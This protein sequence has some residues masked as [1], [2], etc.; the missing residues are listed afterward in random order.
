MSDYEELQS[1]I[2][3]IVDAAI[4]S[5]MINHTYMKSGNGEWW[6]SQD[7]GITVYSDGH[8][9]LTQSGLGP[10]RDPDPFAHGEWNP[11]A[12]W[13]KWRTEIPAAFTNW[14]SL[15]DPKVCDGA[16]KDNGKVR[17]TIGLEP[18][19]SKQSLNPQGVALAKDVHTIS[20]TMAK[21]AGKA[22]LEFT[23]TVVTPLNTAIPQQYA[24]AYLLGVLLQAEKNVW[25]KARK[26]VM[27]IAD[28]AKEAMEKAN[29]AEGGGGELP[30]WVELLGA[31][32]GAASLFV[33]D[34]ATTGIV[35]EGMEHTALVLGGL[36]GMQKEEPV[37]NPLGADNPEDVLEKIKKAI[38]E[39][40]K[41][42]VT[43]ENKISTAA[44]QA[45][46]TIRGS[47]STYDLSKPTQLFGAR[48]EG[49]VVDPKN[50]AVNIS[51][52]KSLATVEMHNIAAELTSAC[53]SVEASYTYDPFD[54]PGDIGANPFS[55]YGDLCWEL[56]QV[57][58]DSA[59]IMRESAA[60]LVDVANDFGNTDGNIVKSA[61]DKDRADIAKGSGAYPIP[62]PEPEPPHGMGHMYAI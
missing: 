20:E 24:V 27:S 62:P 60:V 56:E 29:Y 14:D 19:L 40:N 37:K 38:A 9:T 46:S 36:E 21:V 7:L 47:V 25:T 16:L 15:P 49:D 41:Q 61:L 11:F 55:G 8:Y 18:D 53:N 3:K 31:V 42:M 6:Y 51:D 34:G 57:L 30:A 2:P 39:A 13:Q 50:I 58:T 35:L 1:L 45:V 17:S 33:T 32:A 5:D 54:R 10:A 52:L 23:R 4:D 28:N 26:S 12:A 22:M 44:Y 43:E 48:T 59:W